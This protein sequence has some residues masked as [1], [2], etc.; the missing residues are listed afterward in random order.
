[1]KQKRKI[2]DR[3]MGGQTDLLE[4]CINSQRLLDKVLLCMRDAIIVTDLKGHIL[5]TNPVVDKVLGFTSDE[6]KNK[7]LSVLFTPED[8]IYLYPNLLCMAQKNESFEGELM[9]IR[10]DGTRFFT[11]ITF[12]TY[13]DPKQDKSRI[14]LSIQ[15]IDKEKQLEKTFRGIHYTDLIKV[16]SGIAHEIRNPLVGIGGFANR[17]YKSC[18]T[19]DE[20]DKFYEHIINN[21]RKIEGLI[22]KVEF[23]ANLPKPHFTEEA[24]GELIEEALQPYLQQINEKKIDLSINVEKVVMLVDLDLVVRVFSILLEN[25]LDA[26]FGIGRILIKSE[27]ND[28]QY[29]IYVSDTGSGI[30]PEDLPYIFNPF[31]STKADGAGIDLATAKR[32]MALHGGDI[33]VTSKQTKG[34][35]F[36]LVFPLERRRP[37]RI[38][39]LEIK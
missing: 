35:T 31:F 38:S 34:T 12:Q 24:I 33:E 19:I 4:A 32:I 17:L 16:A 6:L 23:F 22:R 28:N 29:K 26:M 21:V 20:H 39:T 11:F 36:L 3:E 9:L 27:T 2:E 7:D 13:L 8:L 5:F 18:R 30:S 1:M 37:I 14:V 15:D 25:A 10:K